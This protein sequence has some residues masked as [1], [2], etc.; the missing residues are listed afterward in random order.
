M[1]AAPSR[2]AYTASS[3]LRGSIPV[4]IS[5]VVSVKGERGEAGG[6]GEGSGFCLC[7]TATACGLSLSLGR[8][9][10][11]QSVPFT[12]I[13]VSAAEELVS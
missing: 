5:T 8:A 11:L 3:L 9:G 4:E 10:Y 1:R 7:P 12:D 2:S 6:G 13:R